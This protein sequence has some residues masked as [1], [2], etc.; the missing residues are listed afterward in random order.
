VLGEA[1]VV[2]AVVVQ[3]VK[4]AN[5]SSKTPVNRYFEFLE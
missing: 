1:V 4:M 2:T 5:E 3:P